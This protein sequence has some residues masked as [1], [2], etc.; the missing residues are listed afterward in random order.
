MTNIPFSLEAELYDVLDQRLGTTVVPPD[1]S[2]GFKCLSQQQVGTVIPD[3]V[4]IS[5]PQCEPQLDGGFEGLTAFESAIVAAL[6]SGRPMRKETLARQLYTRVERIAPNLTALKRRGIVCELPTGSYALNGGAV[7]KDLHVVAV[8]A[9][10]SRWRD[11]ILQAES[12]LQFANQSFVALPS[13][14]ATNN[15]KLL[16]QC[17]E[18]GVGVL[19]VEPESVH[20]ISAARTSQPRSPDWVWLVSRAVRFGH[21]NTIQD[22]LQQTL[23]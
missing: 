1:S 3:Y 7:P 23:I 9:K 8:E 12:Y 5:C 16:R 14:L 17:R 20:L 13:I 22:P 21:Q 15:D 19:G 2:D 10:L 18:R 11:A 4:L 6:L